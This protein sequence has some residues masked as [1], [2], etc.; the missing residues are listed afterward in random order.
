MDWLFPNIHRFITL[1]VTILFYGMTGMVITLL[2]FFSGSG[3]YE[4]WEILMAAV[5]GTAAVYGTLFY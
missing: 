3:F 4:G 1:P 2:I 5:I